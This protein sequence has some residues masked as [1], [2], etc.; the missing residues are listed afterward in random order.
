M[1]QHD[2]RGPQPLCMGHCSWA[3]IHRVTTWLTPAPIGTP[4]EALAYPGSR[5]LHHCTAGSRMQEDGLKSLT[6]LAQSAA[7]CCHE[8]RVAAHLGCPHH[9]N[10]PCGTMLMR[11]RIAWEGDTIT[12]EELAVI[13]KWPR[14]RAISFST[15]QALGLT[16]LHTLS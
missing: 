16:A 10:Y 7:I 11:R 5:P 12:G 13:W 4:A 15:L 2:R 14:Y 1:T 3:H 6:A 8:T 9:C